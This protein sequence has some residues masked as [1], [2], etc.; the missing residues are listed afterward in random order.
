MHV[1]NTSCATDGK[2]NMTVRCR[3]FAGEGMCDNEIQV[4]T[5]NRVGVYDD[6]AEHYTTVH[7]LSKDDCDF[8]GEIAGR[9]RTNQSLVKA[10]SKNY[11]GR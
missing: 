8:L 9:V 5:N 3:A 11:L 4:D 7:H 6:V 1:K 10:Q 2:V